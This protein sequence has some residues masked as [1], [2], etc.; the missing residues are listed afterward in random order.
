MRAG[1][2][3]AVAPRAPS[4]IDAAAKLRQHGVDVVS[5]H[6]QHGDGD[7]ARQLGEGPA[8]ADRHHQAERRVIDHADD[9][10]HAGGHHLLDEERRRRDSSVGQPVA[11]LVDRRLDTIRR[12]SEADG[13]HIALV[14]DPGAVGLEHQRR[15]PVARL[16]GTGYRNPPPGQPRLDRRL[17]HHQPARVAIEGE[18]LLAQRLDVRIPPRDHLTPLFAQRPDSNSPAGKVFSKVSRR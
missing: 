18:G 7:I 14:H 10:L 16:H 12:Q 17:R 15:S 2:S 13:A 3:T 11:H 9:H 6:R 5:G 1:R 8:H 4:R